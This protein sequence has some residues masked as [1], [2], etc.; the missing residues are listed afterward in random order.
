MRRGGGGGGCDCEVSANEYSCA[1]GAQIN[2]GDLTPYD[3][4]LTVA[5][6]EL[7]PRILTFAISCWYKHHTYNNM[8]ILELSISWKIATGIKSANPT[9]AGTIYFRTFPGVPGQ[10]FKNS[11]S[12]LEASLM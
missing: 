9:Q 6:N 12:L 2:F 3:V 1:H 4:K 7:A 8:N 11:N 10:K 5:G